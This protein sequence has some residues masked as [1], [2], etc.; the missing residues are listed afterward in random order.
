MVITRK[1]LRNE[2]DNIINKES[3]RNINLIV[4][5][6]EGHKIPND[7]TNIVKNPFLSF[8]NSC[9]ISL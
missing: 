2:F 9:G 5:Y 1:I 4:Y 7:L 6:L 3:F 8:C